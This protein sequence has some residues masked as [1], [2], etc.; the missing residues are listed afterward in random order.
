MSNRF[1]VEDDSPAPVQSERFVIEEDDVKPHSQNQGFKFS[2]F[3]EPP[4]AL[5]EAGLAMSSGLGGQI[6]GGLSGLGSLIA[7]R[8]LEESANT[9]RSVQDTLSYKPKTDLGEGL[10]TAISYPFEKG[11]EAT[12]AGGGAIGEK[13]AGES[14]RLVGEAIGEQVI[15]VVSTLAG[16][17]GALKNARTS[18]TNAKQVAI[19]KSIND[20]ARIDAAKLAVE[21]YGLSLDPVVS[22]PT[23]LN[24]IRAT[25]VGQDYLNALIRQQNEPKVASILK[26]D[27]GIPKKTPLTSVAPFEAVRESAGAAKRNIQTMSG[28]SDDGT[29][30]NAISALQ[31]EALIGGKAAAKKVNVL[32]GDAN[33]LL[34]GE[35]SGARLIAEIEHLRKTARDL[36]KAQEMK[37]TQRAI[38]DAN[39]GI[40]NALESMIERNL[41]S[42]GLVDLLSEFREG[43]VRMA[44]SYTLQEA[45]N[46]NTGLVDPLLIAKMTSKDNALTGTFSDIGKIAGNYPE[47]LGVKPGAPGGLKEFTATHLTRTGPAGMAGYV[48]GGMFGQPLLGAGIGAGLGEIFGNIYGKRIAR[49]PTVQQSISVPPDFRPTGM[50]TP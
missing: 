48:A 26:T 1:I 15:P 17:Y 46:L 47:V 39:I 4:A 43:R 8:G 38:A 10:M 2:D 40:A 49:N 42:R 19:D 27:I 22:N 41:Q 20:A 31:P 5:L 37:P 12:K 33:K 29:T 6:S 34:S 25:A 18:A 14:G 36:Y 16:G 32:I 23:K 7:G 30:I 24:A 28:F 9:V 3:L 45:T 35:V 44:K 13:I 50:M 11:M 21:K